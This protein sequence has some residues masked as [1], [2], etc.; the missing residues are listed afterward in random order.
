MWLTYFPGVLILVYRYST[1]YLTDDLCW[2]TRVH[3]TCLPIY[4]LWELFIT[5]F[6]WF[7]SRFCCVHDTKWST[8]TLENLALTDDVEYKFD[9]L[10]VL[11]S[12]NAIRNVMLLCVDARIYVLVECNCA[13]RLI[14]NAWVLTQ[15]FPLPEAHQNLCA[16]VWEFSVA[17]FLQTC[18]FPL[19]NYRV[20]LDSDTWRS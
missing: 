9:L 15:K 19:R 3:Y 13:S 4:A 18:V 12:V 20:S 16:L 10:H 8:M 1:L 17:T 5:W 2:C 7:V 14:S 6:C 11:L